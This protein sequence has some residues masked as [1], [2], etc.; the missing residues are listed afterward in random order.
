MSFGDW[1]QIPKVMPLEKRV[2][3]MAF[4]MI[5]YYWLLT[6]NIP[7][8]YQALWDTKST[9]YEYPEYGLQRSII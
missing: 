9:N 7:G 2:L 3:V 4:G 1:A 5:S 8:G 6:G